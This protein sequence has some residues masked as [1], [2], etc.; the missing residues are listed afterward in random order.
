MGME[1]IS[2]SAAVF[3]SASTFGRHSE[4]DWTF[5][6]KE[7]ESYCLNVNGRSCGMSSARTGRGQGRGKLNLDVFVVAFV[8]D[9]VIASIL[10]TITKL[11][12]NLLAII[13]IS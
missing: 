11:N 10:H 9:N 1:T 7:G 5:G 12:Q 3:L 8:S 2:W 6:A 4:N 13:T